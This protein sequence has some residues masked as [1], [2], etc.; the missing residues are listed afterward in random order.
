MR[1]LFHPKFPGILDP[2]HPVYTIHDN[3]M[4]KPTTV[5][6]AQISRH[7]KTS[8]Q[9]PFS[10]SLPSCLLSV[11]RITDDLVQ[12]DC[13]TIAFEIIRYKSLQLEAQNKP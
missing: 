8:K 5:F 7:V 1:G 10:C 4:C 6:Y 13:P 3:F 12:Q 9:F 2:L 11:L